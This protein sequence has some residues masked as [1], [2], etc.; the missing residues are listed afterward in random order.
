MYISLIKTLSF[1]HRWIHVVMLVF[2]FFAATWDN[3][4]LGASPLQVLGFCVLFLAVLS[5]WFLIKVKVKSDFILSIFVSVLLINVIGLLFEKTEFST[6]ALSLKII[7]P[8]SLFSYFRRS[9]L[10]KFFL[11]GFFITFL[12]SSVFPIL[13]LFYEI[14][15]DPIREVYQTES[16]GGGLR[17][18]GFYSDLFGYMSHLIGCYMIYCYFFIKSSKYKRKHWPFTLTGYILIT[19]LFLVGIYNLRHQA[20]WAVSLVLISLFYLHVRRSLNRSMRVMLILA[21][22]CAAYYFYS[23]VFETLFAKD[24]NVVNGDTSESAA[25][26]GR[27]GLWERYFVYW[28]GFSTLSK[29][30]GVGFESHWA[31]GTMMSGGMHN[32]YVRLFFSSG[33]FG[34]TIYVYWLLQKLVYSNKV[35]SSEFRY[36]YRSALAVLMLYSISSLPLLSAGALTYIL[37]AIIAQINYLKLS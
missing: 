3:K 19:C 6:F 30:F 22:V 27:Y 37:M 5:S 10:N 18:S 32:D 28:S 34:I 23:E 16:R 21:V 26:N 4:G 14:L 33:I 2:P 36:I 17:L 35:K 29:V 1:E 13:T 8:F 11:E 25:L 9:M 20:S 12:I 31:A 24:I 15:F 7:L